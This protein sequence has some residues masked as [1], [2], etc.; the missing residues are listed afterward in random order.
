M[1]MEFT[2]NACKA[3]ASRWGRGSRP[4]AVSCPHCLMLL[5]S[6]VSSR[7]LMDSAW[8]EAFRGLC[9]ILVQIL[10]APRF[11]LRELMTKRFRPLVFAS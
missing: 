3:G 7:Q 10:A 5:L 4:V 9:Q 8:R 6:D 1:Q 2:C 11:G